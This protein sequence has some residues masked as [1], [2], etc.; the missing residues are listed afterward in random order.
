MMVG[1][2]KAKVSSG[3]VSSRMAFPS[4]DDLIKETPYRRAL[5]PALELILNLVKVT[6][7]VNHHKDRFLGVPAREQALF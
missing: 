7:E 6:T 1:W 3:D 4:S 5:Q 2:Q